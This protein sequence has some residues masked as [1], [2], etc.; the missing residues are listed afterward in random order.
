MFL[1]LGVTDGD[2]D[3][4]TVLLTRAPGTQRTLNTG[5]ALSHNPRATHITFLKCET[6]PL[7]ALGKLVLRMLNE[8]LFRTR[9]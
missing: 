2:R 6:L 1:V 8:K 9:T 4:A 5:T 3:C 7:F